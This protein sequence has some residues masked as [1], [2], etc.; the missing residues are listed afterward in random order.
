[1]LSIKELLFF[2]IADVYA[3]NANEILVGKVSGSSFP[4]FLAYKLRKIISLITSL[5][6]SNGFS[7]MNTNLLGNFTVCLTH[8]QIFKSLFD[9]HE[10]FSLKA[11]NIYG[12]EMIKLQYTNL[13]RNL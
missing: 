7:F 2:D 4:P 13:F 5:V 9:I 3:A 6:L 12:H 8:V 11:S 10:E 1:M